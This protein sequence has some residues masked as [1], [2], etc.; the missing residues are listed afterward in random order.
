MEQDAQKTEMIPG[1]NG[2]RLK[3]NVKGC[4][5]N[6]PNGR[7]IGAISIKS[8]L[9]KLLDGEITIEEAGEKFK[10][11]RREIILLEIV[12]DAMNDE[13]PNTRLKAAAWIADRTEGKPSQ[14][15]E[16]SGDEEK[17]VRLS[18]EAKDL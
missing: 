3:K 6:N 9:N 15:V 16:L 13:D 2:G 8:A 14:P 11:T 10:M 7:P 5:C 18:W 12:R 1:R 17:P 4:K